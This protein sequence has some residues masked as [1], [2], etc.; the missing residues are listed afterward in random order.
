[1]KLASKSWPR[2]VNAKYRY[3]N[4]QGYIVIKNPEHHRANS[5]GWIKEH[6]II[7]EQSNGKLIPDGWVIHHLNGIKHDNRPIN[8]VAL[9]S[10][11]HGIV[12]QA[13]AKRIQELEGLLNQ[14]HQLL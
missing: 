7:W 5:L 10:M 8:L 4:K 1:M 12:L 13:K 9:P 2:I 11:K 6:M 3:T 14:Q